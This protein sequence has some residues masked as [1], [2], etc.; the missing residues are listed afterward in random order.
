MEQKL[1]IE[2]MTVHSGGPFVAIVLAMPSKNVDLSSL[3]IDSMMLQM[4]PK[5]KLTR[6]DR[7]LL[8]GRL[9]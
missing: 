4:E 1:P 6:L 3:G 5:R 9:V 2:R 8:F 7:T